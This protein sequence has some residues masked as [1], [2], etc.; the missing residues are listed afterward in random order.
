VILGA[1]VLFVGLKWGTIGG[2][3]V[4]ANRDENPINYWL[5][6]SVTALALIV[7]II[8]LIGSVIWP[9]RFRLD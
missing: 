3:G 6:I 8:V 9:D 7:A 2:G 5:G 1:G 4:G